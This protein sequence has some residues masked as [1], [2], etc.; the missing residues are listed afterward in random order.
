MCIHQH[1][2]MLTFEHILNLQKT[3]L[4]LEDL[5]TVSDVILCD[6]AVI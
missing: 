1:I 5:S 2:N 3:S 6:K 4:H